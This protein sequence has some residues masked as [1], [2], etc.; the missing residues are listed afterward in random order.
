MKKLVF[1]DFIPQRLPFGVLE[2]KDSVME[3]I[4]TFITD[5]KSFTLLNMETTNDGRTLR[6]WGVLSGRSKRGITKLFSYSMM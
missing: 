6:L 2:S 4:N 1:Y 5:N 3:K